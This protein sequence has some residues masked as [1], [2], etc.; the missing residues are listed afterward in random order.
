[1]NYRLLTS[2]LLFGLLASTNAS[3]ESFPNRPIQVI[4]PYGVGGGGDQTARVFGQELSSLLKQ[5]IIVDNRPGGNSII[6]ARA[7]ALAEPDGHT[8]MLTSGSTVSVLPHLVKQLPIDPERDFVPVGK[9]A[10]VPFYLV[11]HPSL[12]VN[13]VQE[14]IAYATANPGKVTYGSAGN[15]TGSHLGVELLK[16]AGK[17]DLL[18]VPYKGVA[19]ALPDLISGRISLVI[20]DYAVIGSAMKAGSVRTI[21]VTTRDRSTQLP[22]VPTIAEQ[23]VP[24]FHLELWWGLFAPKGTPKPVVEKLSANLMTALKAPSVVDALQ[25]IGYAADPTTPAQLEE[26]TKAE[27]KMWRDLISKA[28]IKAD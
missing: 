26:L 18:H 22:D 14:L 2:A 6:G 12:P 21:A 20:S 24:N 11:V 16:S 25:K 5:S 8:L 27:S 28:G 7:V 9:V 10:K 19:Q 1:M 3:G 4:V 13:N 15:G 17:I 23:G